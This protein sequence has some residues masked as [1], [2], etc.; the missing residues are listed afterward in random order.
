MKQTRWIGW[1]ILAVL[2]AAGAL[3]LNTDANAFSQSTSPDLSASTILVWPGLARPGQSVTYTIVITNN[4]STGAAVRLTDTLPSGLTYVSGTL[5]HTLPISAV[6]R[7]DPLHGVLSAY[8]WQFPDTLDKGRLPALGVATVTFAVVA[9]GSRPITN[10]MQ[11]E[12]QNQAYAIPPAVLETAPW[13]TWLPVVFNAWSAPVNVPAQDIYQLVVCDAQF[14]PELLNGAPAQGTVRSDAVK[15]P[16]ALV[17]SYY[18]DTYVNRHCLKRTYLAFELDEDQAR[19][20]SPHPALVLKRHPG[21]V[22]TPMEIAVHREMYTGNPGDFS[23]ALWTGW[24]TPAAGNITITGDGDWS[25][26]LNW[27]PSAGRSAFLIKLADESP[28]ESRS[29]GTISAYLESRP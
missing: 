5:T 12:D 23:P 7:L 10:T 24:E 1:I 18:Y 17:V 29:N 15:P 3:A 14:G 27:T 6:I 21:Y 20:L 4:G 8:T 22:A 28:G 13:Q 9:Q 16:M 26:P 11:L 2:L 25:I 19:R